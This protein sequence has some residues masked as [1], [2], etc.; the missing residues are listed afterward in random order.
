MASRLLSPRPWLSFVAFDSV[1]FGLTSRPHSLRYYTPAF[2]A[3]IAL[4]LSAAYAPSRPF[5]LLAHSLGSLGAARAALDANGRCKALVLIA[6]AMVPRAPLPRPVRAVMRGIMYG[7]AWVAVG[8]SVLLSPLLALVLRRVVGRRPFWRRGLAL[9]RADMDPP[10]EMVEGYFAPTNAER[11]GKGVLNF[12]RAALMDRA[13]ALGEGEDYVSMLQEMG[14]GGPRVLVVHGE[15]DRV[16]P[17]INSRRL[18]DAIPG[19]RLV[20]MEG[21][22]HVPHEEEPEVFADIVGE[23]LEKAGLAMP[24]V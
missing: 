24:D 2:S 1:G 22:G 6:P 18:V 15:Q 13:R 7:L 20:V 19:A 17:V 8:L 16:V 14:E 23:F 5:A 11:W 9:A 3:R 12:C 4:A 10:E 21:C